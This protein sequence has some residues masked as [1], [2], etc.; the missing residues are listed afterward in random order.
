MASTITTTIRT[1]EL[2]G[3]RE[4]LDRGGQLIEVLP[5]EEYAWG[6]LPGAVHVPLKELTPQ[7]TAGLDKARPVALYCWDAL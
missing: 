5:A 1:V 6:H 4:L 3:L 7:T 2:E